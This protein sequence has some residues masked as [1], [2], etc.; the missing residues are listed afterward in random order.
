MK[1]RARTGYTR[2]PGASRPVVAYWILQIETPAGGIGRS[3]IASRPSSAP[4]IIDEPLFIV[5]Q[6]RGT[7]KKVSRYPLDGTCEIL[8]DAPPPVGFS[9]SVG[10][11]SSGSSVVAA[12][13]R[14]VPTLSP[15][16]GGHKSTP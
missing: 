9:C 10:H 8:S 16:K 12:L 1:R 6:R 13:G 11:G 2:L 5:H 4:L 7:P 3:P 15:V 14:T